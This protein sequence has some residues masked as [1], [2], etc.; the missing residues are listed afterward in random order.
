MAEVLHGVLLECG[1]SSHR[2][3]GAARRLKS[4]TRTC[5]TPK[6]SQNPAEILIYSFAFIRVIR[7][8]KIED[9]DESEDEAA[10]TNKTRTFVQLITRIN[11]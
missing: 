1:A 6:A 7:G 11:F 10:V 8:K 2:F 5:R 3:L 4:D 9:D